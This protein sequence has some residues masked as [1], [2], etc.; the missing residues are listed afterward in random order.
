MKK[1]V[2]VFAMLALCAVMLSGCTFESEAEKEA[3]V[4]KEVAAFPFFYSADTY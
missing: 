4:T 1:V 2:S 3:R